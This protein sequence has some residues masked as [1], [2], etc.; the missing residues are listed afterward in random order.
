MTITYRILQG[1]VIVALAVLLWFFIVGLGDGSIDGSNMLLWLVLL[2]V[3]GGA[4][5]EAAQLRS[6]GKPGVACLLLALPAVPAVFFG[7][8]FGLFVILQP[9]MR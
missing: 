4:L 7:L 6:G 3:P 2:V 5:V 8:F 1:V 9:D